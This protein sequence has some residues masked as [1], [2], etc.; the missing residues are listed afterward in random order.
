M[1]TIIEGARIVAALGV[2]G[3]FAA[4]VCFGLIDSGNLPIFYRMGA[5]FFCS[6]AAFLVL[7][8]IS[9]VLCYGRSGR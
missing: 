6:L 9:A 2:A 1:K 7:S 5:V 4:M 3:G 8:V